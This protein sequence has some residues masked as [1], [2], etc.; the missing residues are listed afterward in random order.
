[1]L[2]DAM[3]DAYLARI[4]AERPERADLAALTHL[5][6]RQVLSVPF[7]NL[8]YHLDEPIHMDEQVLDKIVRQRRGGGCYEVNPALSFLLTALGYQVEILPGRVHRPGGTLGAALCHLALRVTVD[9]E[10]WLVDT[11]FGRNSRHP[12][13][14]A[15]RE[16]QQDPDGEYRL[17]DVEGGGFDVFLNGK[18]LYRLEDRPVRIEDFRPTLWWY[19]TAP[20]SP[21]MQ[22]VFCSLRT[23][24]GR[25]TLKGNQLSTVAGGERGTQEFG[26]DAAVLEAYK[27]YFGFSL[28]RLP[29]QPSGGVTAA[30]QTG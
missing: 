19:R 18:P 3:V 9:G 28:D 12:L 30:V 26:T 11:G 1:M 13:R 15:S 8:G 25:I 24:D 22:D 16:V 20:E 5:Q 6:E 7:E 17:A 27:T 23:E 29:D 14:L 2:D 10:Q 4:G 21:F